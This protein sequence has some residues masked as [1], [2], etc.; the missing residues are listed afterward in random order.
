MSKNLKMAVVAG[1]VVAV[2]CAAVVLLTPTFGKVVGYANEQPKTRLQQLPGVRLG[3]ELPEVV[4]LGEALFELRP[5]LKDQYWAEP[6]EVVEKEGC[7]LLVYA[8]KVPIYEWLGRQQV[9][10]PTEKYLYVSVTKRELRVR[11][12]RWCE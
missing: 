5:H 10:T 9:V 4:R 7:W 2:L 12:G 8:R 1:G 6:A 3:S 11:I